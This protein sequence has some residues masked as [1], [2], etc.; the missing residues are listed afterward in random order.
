MPLHPVLLCLDEAAN[1]AAD[2]AG[3]RK[4]VAALVSCCE[5]A[6]KV[7]KDY[8][9]SANTAGDRHSI[10][11]WIGAD[12]SRQ[13][14]EIS[15]TA[16]EV[17]RTAFTEANAMVGNSLSLEENLIVLPYRMLRPAETGR[18]A[19]RAA[20]DVLEL[21]IARLRQLAKGLG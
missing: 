7:W 15:L 1:G 20:I 11:S 13:L 12:R 18:D 10:V 8:L 3:L 16:T 6:K 17:L 5:E 19:A 2:P 14:H 9:N 4:H 21:R